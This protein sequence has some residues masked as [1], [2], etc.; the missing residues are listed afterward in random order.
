MKVFEFNTITY[1]KNK[2]TPLKYNINLDGLEASHHKIFKYDHS[3]NIIFKESFELE[4]LKGKK[5]LFIV[6]FIGNGI[7]AR[8]IIQL[9]SLSLI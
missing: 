3:K 6:E 5:G 7:S 4:E 1:Y 9:G 8:A 2:K